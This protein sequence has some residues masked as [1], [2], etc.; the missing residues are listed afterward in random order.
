MLGETTKAVVALLAFAEY[1]EPTEGNRSRLESLKQSA[2]QQARLRRLFES[3]L[4]SE[5]GCSSP[6]FSWP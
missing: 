5:A 2:E 1:D 6:A 3:P 4:Y